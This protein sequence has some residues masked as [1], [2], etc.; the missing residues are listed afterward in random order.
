M[1]T[2]IK[3]QN[4]DFCIIA[5]DIEFFIEAIHKG[6][7]KYSFINNLNAILSEFNVNVDDEKA[8]ESQWIVSKKQGKLFFKEA[9]ELLSDRT[10]RAYLEKMLDEDRRCSE[11]ENAKKANLNNAITEGH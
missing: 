11:W 7:L 3:G 5:E 1:K 10:Y 4:Y 8:S 6:S 2:L 9:M